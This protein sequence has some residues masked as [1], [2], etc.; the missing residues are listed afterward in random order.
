MSTHRVV[1]VRHAK[2]VSYSPGTDD[3]RPLADSG[4]TQAQELGRRLA[5]V[6]QAADNVFVSPAL[7][8]QET[9]Q[10]LAKGAGLT[11]ETMPTVQTDEVI[12]SGSPMEMMEAVRMG[13]N[14]TTSILVGHEP[15]VS[16]LAVLLTKEG[17]ASEVEMGMPTGSAAV[18]EWERD[19]KEW[20]SH[21]AIL[22]DFVHVRH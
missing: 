19:W 21:C 7:R 5:K 12:Y 3:K 6:I 22:A 10:N 18:V 15:T 2:A 16:S 9:W 14:G 17:Q 4:R 13:S 20:H 8:A 1:I 11:E